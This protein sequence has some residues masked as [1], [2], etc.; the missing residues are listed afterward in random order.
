MEKEGK[1]CLPVVENAPTDVSLSIK[2]RGD[3]VLSARPAIDEHVDGDTCRRLEK[4]TCR[5]FFFR[6]VSAKQF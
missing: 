1:T 3:S 5:S 4:P 2:Q 6:P